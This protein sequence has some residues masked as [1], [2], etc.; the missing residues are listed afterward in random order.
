MAS[1]GRHSQQWFI[2]LIPFHSI[3]FLSIPFHSIPLIHDLG[4]TVL[5]T[6]I[7]D[8]DEDVDADDD[9]R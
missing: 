3:P 1:A 2:P 4:P 9:V 5:P 7:T 6:F 8:E